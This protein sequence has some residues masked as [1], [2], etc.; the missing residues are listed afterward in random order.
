MAKRPKIPRTHQMISVFRRQ[1]HKSDWKITGIVRIG[2]NRWKVT[3]K[4]QVTGKTRTAF[5]DKSDMRSLRKF[6]SVVRHQV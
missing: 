4:D 1:L 6:K 3:V 5:V 2:Q